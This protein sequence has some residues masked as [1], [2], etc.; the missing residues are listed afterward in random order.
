MLAA[1][2]KSLEGLKF[3]IYV[4]PKL[5]GI[6]CLII[7]GIAVSRTLKPIPN[8]YI[9]E[10]L[11]DLPTGLDGELMLNSVD[12][13][14]NDVQSAVM[15]EDGEPDFLYCV[16]DY[17]IEDTEFGKRL[18][19][20]RSITKNSKVKSV[21]SV[22]VHDESLLREIE[23]QYV[24][25]GYEGIMLRSTDG[26]Y[27]Y[28]RSTI[29]EGYLMKYKHFNDAEA[30]IIGF[31]EL[32]RNDNEKTKDAL[33]HSVRSSHLAG[34]R[35]ANCLGS[36]IVYDDLLDI[37]FNVGSGFTQEQRD[38]IWANQKK[39][40]GKQITYTYQELSSKGVPRFPTFKCFRED[41]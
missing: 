40:M 5:D 33:G 26:L 8:K 25:D 13:D 23:Q 19:L 35:R 34:L 28:G 9:Q 3:P 21:E 18:H 39:Y 20:L 2:L 27:K 22:F 24:K 16:F 41:I 37:E 36:L 10:Q 15:S 30:I 6:R 12:A 1:T 38:E 11:K 7:D 31:E 17:V 4:Q 32:N 29:T 14:F